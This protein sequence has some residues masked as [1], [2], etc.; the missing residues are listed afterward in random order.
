MNCFKRMLK[1]PMSKEQIQIE[2][3]VSRME[4][5]CNE[6]DY[7]VMELKELLLMCN[8]NQKIFD[9]VLHLMNIRNI[10][11]FITRGSYIVFGKVI[12]G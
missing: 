2:K 6:I 5:R 1:T 11:Y 7:R 8:Y 9:E 10:G 4:E 3:I 12:E